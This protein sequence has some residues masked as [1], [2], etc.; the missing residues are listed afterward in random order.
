MYV[1]N[2]EDWKRYG[3]CCIR[4]YMLGGTCTLLVPT[5]GLLV[6]MGSRAG[7]VA[8]FLPM[9]M[10]CSETPQLDWVVGLRGRGGGST[11]VV[12]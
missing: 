5:A 9:G 1:C 3:I 8:S 2:D 10:K 12:L 11:S 6:W 7:S 4:I